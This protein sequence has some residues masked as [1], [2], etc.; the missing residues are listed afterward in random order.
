[1]GSPGSLLLRRG[2]LFEAPLP[3]AEAL[4]QRHIR[5][6]LDRRFQVRT[7]IAKFRDVVD[8]FAVLTS[9]KHLPTFARR[10]ACRRLDELVNR[11]AAPNPHYKSRRS[12][13]WDSATDYEVLRTGYG[14]AKEWVSSNVNLM[15]DDQF[16]ESLFNCCNREKTRWG[17]GL[18]V[19][20]LRAL[21][22]LVRLQ[23][24][25]HHITSL[26]PSLFGLAVRLSFLILINDN[27]NTNSL[28][29]EDRA[30]RARI[31]CLFTDVAIW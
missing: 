20:R 27:P 23:L 11:G 10:I 4:D 1:M 26:S 18:A 5:S 25:M 3:S 17:N 13:S 28:W 31:I 6:V 21:H 14:N 16:G 9:H 2:T 7:E 22:V 24:S 8:S 19:L 29:E 15:S 12:N 30:S